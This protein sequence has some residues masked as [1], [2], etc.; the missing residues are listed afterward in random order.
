[1]VRHFPGPAFSV[2]SQTLAGADPGFSNRA[3]AQVERG[4][5]EYGGECPHPRNFFNFLPLNGASCEH[6]DTNRQFTRPV[7]I[8]LKTCKNDSHGDSA[9]YKDVRANAKCLLYSTKKTTISRFV[10]FINVICGR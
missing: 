10:S 6:S 2:D 1:M 3:G 8:R 5:R 9:L 4:R 7:A